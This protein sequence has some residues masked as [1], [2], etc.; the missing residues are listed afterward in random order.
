MI[1][2]RGLSWP[3]SYSPDVR[4][5][6]FAGYRDDTWNVW[7]LERAT[8]QERRLTQNRRLDVY[9]RYPSWSPRGDRIGYAQAAPRG[10][11]VLL[12]VGAAAR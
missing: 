10:A 12:D 2:K 11:V 3:F 1:E 4:Y 5:V 8:R 6:A 9:M 7:L